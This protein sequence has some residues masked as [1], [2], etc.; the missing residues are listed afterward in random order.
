MSWIIF[1]AFHKFLEAGQVDDSPI[2]D[3]PLPAPSPS[4]KRTGGKLQEDARPKAKA[5]AKSK[6][7]KPKMKEN[8]PNLQQDV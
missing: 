5:K 4:K 6:S 8:I 2:A 1:H 7:K 3:T